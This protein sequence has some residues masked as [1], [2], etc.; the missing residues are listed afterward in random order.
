MFLL[1]RL[2]LYAIAGAAFVLALLGIYW[3][4]RKDGAAAVK[5]DANEAR[6]DAVKTAKDV[7]DEIRS[8]DDPAF[9]DRASQ[10]V[11]KD[12]GQ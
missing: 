12:S 6:M 1:G 11:R 10:W 9:V 3:S 2:K 4:G 8:L 7:E 5:A